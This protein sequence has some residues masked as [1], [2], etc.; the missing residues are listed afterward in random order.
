MSTT[1]PPK[2]ARGDENGPR[3]TKRQKEL[4][5]HPLE[6]SQEPMETEEAFSDR[7][8][9]YYEQKTTFKA[10]IPENI[11]KLELQKRIKNTLRKQ[12]GWTME[13][14]TT[15]FDYNAETYASHYLTISDVVRKHHGQLRNLTA[16]TLDP[17]GKPR[18]QS[19]I[20]FEEPKNYIALL[21]IQ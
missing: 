8:R 1:Q 3:T 16:T 20:F 7:R 12:A 2:R 11:N 9:A 4:S 15:S 21:K 13:L 10:W 5:K 6:P 18:G 14:H 17:L 19:Q